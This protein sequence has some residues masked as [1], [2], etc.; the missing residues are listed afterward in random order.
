MYF[1]F[2]HIAVH[3]GLKIDVATYLELEVSTS[4]KEFEEEFATKLRLDR[5]QYR[6]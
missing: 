2:L 1:T 5:I 4:A 3:T 6:E